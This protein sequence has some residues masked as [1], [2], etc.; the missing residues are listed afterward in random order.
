MR[1]VSYYKEEM[2][3]NKREHRGKKHSM[4][5]VSKHKYFRVPRTIITGWEQ[6]TDRGSGQATHRRLHGPR[7]GVG[8][9]PVRSRQ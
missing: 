3:I 4:T 8:L 2:I 9:F 7:K 5:Y 6:E 1:M